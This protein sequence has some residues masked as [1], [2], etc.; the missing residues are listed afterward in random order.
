MRAAIR[1]FLVFVLSI[2]ESSS[3]L[4]SVSLPVVFFLA[5]YLLITLMLERLKLVL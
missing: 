1:T 3:C 4:F 5:L 2:G